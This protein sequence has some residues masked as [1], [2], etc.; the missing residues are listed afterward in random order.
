MAKQNPLNIKWSRLS[1]FNVPQEARSTAPNTGRVR[2]VFDSQVQCDAFRIGAKTSFARSWG[3]VIGGMFFASPRGRNHIDGEQVLAL[4]SAGL[5]SGR[6]PSVA[7]RWNC[8]PGM[9]SE[10]A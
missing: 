10:E 7:V 8:S 9:R 3:A 1:K 6:S 5:C 2:R 4:W